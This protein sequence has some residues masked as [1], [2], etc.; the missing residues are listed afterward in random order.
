LANTL[1]SASTGTWHDT[2]ADRR[3]EAAGRNTGPGR[4]IRRLEHAAV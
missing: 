2:E 3:I 1:M 4:D